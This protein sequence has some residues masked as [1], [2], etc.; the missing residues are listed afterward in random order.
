MF[1]GIKTL[2]Y[3]CTVKYIRAVEEDAAM[4][5]AIFMPIRLQERKPQ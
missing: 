3:I 4:R 5:A 2:A 1:G